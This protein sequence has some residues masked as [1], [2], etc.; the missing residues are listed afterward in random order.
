MKKLIIMMI[1]SGALPV[2]AM[3]S[4]PRECPQKFIGRVDKIVEAAGP[5][6]SRSVSTVTLSNEETISGI[7]AAKEEIK[8]LQFGSIQLE[9]GE[10]Y[11][12]ALDDH[13]ICQIEV[14]GE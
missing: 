10:R 12:V 7:V 2:E 14:E 6:N 4:T 3:L 13:K 5:T 8:V 1:F 11:V 9:V